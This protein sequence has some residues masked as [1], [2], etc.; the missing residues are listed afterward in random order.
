MCV[1]VCMYRFYGVSE[2]K[3]RSVVSGV[4]DFP[5]KEISLHLSVSGS[6]PWRPLHAKKGAPPP[7][8]FVP[9]QICRADTIGD[10]CKP[11]DEFDFVG[12]AVAFGDCILETGESADPTRDKGEPIELFLYATDTSENIIAILI[13]TKMGSQPKFS[14][15]E[16][17]SAE[18]LLYSRF[19]SENDVHTCDASD[20]VV[21]SKK[22]L[23]PHLLKAKAEVDEWVSKSPSA[24]ETAIQRASLF[25]DGI[26]LSQI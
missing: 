24:I 13:R 19:D 25:T 6:L 2:Y 15:G 7:P 3:R 9:R 21:F 12:V 1:R 8:T 5:E 20:T 16:V 18:N 10:Q 4:P 22:P 14:I 11:G 23:K 17:F 26:T